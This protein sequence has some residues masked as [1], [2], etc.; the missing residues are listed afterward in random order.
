MSD[1]DIE[2]VE[3]DLSTMKAEVKAELRAELEAEQAAKAAE[4]AKIDDAVASATAE[5]Q[6]EHEADIEAKEKAWKSRPAYNRFAKAGDNSGISE[7]VHWIKTGDNG[8]MKVLKPD[9]IKAG[10]QEIELDLPYGHQMKALQEGSDSEG[11]YLVPDDFVNMIVTKREQMSWVR[12]AGVTVRQ[13]NQFHVKIP[14]EGT[15]MSNLA[16]TAEEG[17]YTENDPVFEEVDVQV[18]KFTKLTKVS[19]ELEEDDA[20]GFAQFYANKV[21]TIAAVTE[22]A[23]VATGTGSAQPQGVFVGGTAGLTFDSA[24]NITADEIPELLGKLEPQYRANAS[25]LMH[26]TTEAYLRGIRDTNNWAFDY[27]KPQNLG[28]SGQ[29]FYTSFYGGLPVFRDATAAEIATGN[30]TVL[31]GDFSFYT[32]VERAALSIKRNPYLYMANGQI[33]LFSSFR[34][35]G[36]VT[37]A[38]AFQYGTQA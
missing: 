17:A 23:M 1:K 34:M 9:N 18:F 32:L 21:A 31:V 13:T 6:A 4:Q 8:G 7:L 33:G 12:Q 36:A 37:Q 30:K 10:E 35:G 15:T 38:E 14:V 20:A 11:G 22:G 5:L 26:N 28:V 16:V 25:W 29:A 27:H 19:E 2:V 24:D 3:V